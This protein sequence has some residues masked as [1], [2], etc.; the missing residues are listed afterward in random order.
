MDLKRDSFVIKSIIIGES[1]NYFNLGS[2]Y[3]HH[4]T[5]V[6]HE[7]CL[8][9]WKKFNFPLHKLLPLNQLMLLFCIV[10]NVSCN[11]FLSFFL[12]KKTATN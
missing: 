2:F 9:P 4:H 12:S 3:F 10:L 6:L 11:I 7:V 1:F 8:D 5:M